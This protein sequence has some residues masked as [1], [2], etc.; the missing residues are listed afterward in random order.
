MGAEENSVADHSSPPCRGC[1]ERRKGGPM[2]Q[3]SHRV[4]EQP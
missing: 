1:G 2:G 4:M 3:R